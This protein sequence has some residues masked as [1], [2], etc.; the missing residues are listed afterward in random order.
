MRSTTL[1]LV[2]VAVQAAHSIEEV[3]FRL[4]AEFPPAAFVAGLF[5]S[6]PLL[7]FS[8]ANLLIVA[9]GFA[10]YAWP[11]RRRWP[12]AAAVT[13]GWAIVE[14]I[15]GIGHPVRSLIAG[16]YTA[17]SVSAVVLLVVSLRLI[18]TLRAEGD[19]HPR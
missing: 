11:V 6:D 1:F 13:W 17:G 14:T 9:V 8:I 15:N 16:R 4:H 3:V 2:L 12:S 10:C 5:S 19:V 18:R 7:G